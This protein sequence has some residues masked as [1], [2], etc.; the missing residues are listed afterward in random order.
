[1]SQP[2]LTV[3]RHGET[4]WSRS[5]RH[6]SRTDV[7]LTDLGEAQ[8]RRLGAALA[9]T[10]FELVLCSPRKRAQHT[11]ELA[12]L[13]PVTI[14]VELVEWDYGELEGLTTPEIQQ[15]YPGWSIWDGPWPGGETAAQVAARADRVIDRVLGAAFTQSADTVRVGLVGHGHF[16]RVLAARWVGADITMG[17]WLDLDTAT[18]SELGWSRDTRVIRR[19]NLPAPS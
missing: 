11:A 16:S 19:W 4:E 18:Q 6:T 12:G 7:D 10:C 5:G 14:D 8:A 2:A 9:G 1:L 13:D 17:R 3:V 15:R